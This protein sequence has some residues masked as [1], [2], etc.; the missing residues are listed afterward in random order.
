VSRF[1]VYGFRGMTLDEAREHVRRALGVELEL[2]ES[3]W[4]GGVYYCRRRGT[5]RELML[6]ANV[7][8][9]WSGPGHREF[10]VILQVNDVPGMDDIRQR[11][12]AG[13]PDP[14]LLRSN[15]YADRVE[16]DEDDGALHDG[17]EGGGS[18]DA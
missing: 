18:S 1:D 7:V 15:E 12:T 14:V 9:E 16:G 2:R 6:Y 3:D 17:E 4:W 5:A 8:G 11:L 10:R 13:G